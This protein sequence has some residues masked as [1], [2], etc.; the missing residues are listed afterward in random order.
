MKKNIWLIICIIGCSLLFS[1][2]VMAAA[3]IKVFVNDQQIIA[4][5]PPYIAHNRTMLPA[6]AILEPLG[7]QFLWDS[8]TATV[9]IIKGAKKVSLVIGELSASVN[10]VKYPLEAAAV[11][12]GGRTFLPLRFVAETFNATVNW[13]GAQ[14]TI[15]VYENSIASEPMV[16]TGYYYDANSLVSLQENL[17]L[18]TDTIH[19][20]YRLNTDGLIEEKPFF[21]QGFDLARQNGQGVE[22]LVFASDRAQLIALMNDPA[23]QMVVIDGIYEYLEDRGFDGVNMDFEGI[24]PSQGVQYLAFIKSLK[25]KLAGRYSLS[26]SL[27]ARTSDREVW[28]DGYD[29]AGLAKAADRVMIMAY[30]QHYKG[31][32]PGPVAGN[33]WVESVITYLLPKIPAEKFQLGM[34]IYGYDWAAGSKGKTILLQAARDLALAKGMTINQD[35]AS[36]VSHFDYSDDAGIGHQVWFEDAASVATKLELVKKYHLQGIA[37]WRL[38]IIPGDIW[39]TIKVGQES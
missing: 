24:D 4:D 23:A 1:G 25:A 32:E 36:G 31:G 29:Y 34:G 6:R 16:I 17:P 2:T 13:D 18:I 11:I 21:N 33:D 10:G 8:K 26:L 35:A 15:Q 9:T 22:M 7:G 39:Q 12:K 27:P 19:Y 37:L 3:E 30:D 5:V 38:G 14:H 20:S 28:Y